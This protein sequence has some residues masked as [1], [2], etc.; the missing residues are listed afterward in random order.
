M[1]LLLPCCS[2]KETAKTEFNQF[3]GI[4]INRLYPILEYDSSFN[5]VRLVRYDTMS[6]IV[7]EYKEK[8]LIQSE[9]TIRRITQI[10]NQVVIKEV[11]KKYS[12]LY[13][14]AA[15][16]CAYILDND[17]SKVQYLSKDSALSKEWIFSIDK[18][19]IFNENELVHISTNKISENNTEVRYIVKNIKDRAQTGSLLIVLSNC[20]FDDLGFSLA[21]SVEQKQKAKVVELAITNFGRVLP[22]SNA[23]ID[24]VVVPYQIKEIKSFEKS[25]I[26][27]FFSIPLIE[28]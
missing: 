17:F 16:V 11:K 8:K 18:S 7:F 10:N 28:N 1:I 24:T 26:S 4:E 6:A 20:S 21:K 12:I 14:S 22:G 9:I 2:R 15:S 3:K 27:R 5:R 19:N 23:H 13:D 25:E